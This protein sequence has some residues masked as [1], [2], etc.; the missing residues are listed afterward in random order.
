MVE[1]AAVYTLTCSQINE[2]IGRVVVSPTSSHLAKNE[3]V[4]VLSEIAPLGCVI[5]DPRRK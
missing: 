5:I 2:V 1:L 3:I 4:E